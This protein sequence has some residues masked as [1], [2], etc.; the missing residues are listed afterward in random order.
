MAHYGMLRD[1]AFAED[2]DDIRG[3]D[4]YAAD[5]KIGTVKDV[6]FDHENG[7][8]RY[9]VG[10][11]GHDRHVLI[12]STHVFRSVADED[13]FETD[14]T[15]AEAAKLPRFDEKALENEKDWERH[16]GEQRRVWKEREERYE[17][18]F[19]R[20]WEEDP[21]MHMKD[22][23]NMITPDLGPAEGSG[24]RVITGADLTP[25]R[26]VDKFAQRGP[27]TV[28]S[29]NEV[30]EDTTLRPAPST[31]AG[32]VEAGTWSRSERLQNFQGSLRTCVPRLRESCGFCGSGTRRV[33]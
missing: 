14:L 33:A 12:D 4:L 21:V 24:E 1:Y 10:D 26:I 11:L 18:E 5:G 3:A 16:H 17:S 29:T 22:S 31:N 7:D 6:I 30:A 27:M 32:S 19:K 13:G 28:P 25:R 8:I 2:V 9:I 23:P 15:S 20:K